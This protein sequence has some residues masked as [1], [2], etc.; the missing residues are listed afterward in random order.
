[1]SPGPFIPNHASPALRRAAIFMYIGGGLVA[2][3]GMLLVMGLVARSPEADQQMDRDIQRFMEQQKELPPGVDAPRLKRMAIAVG[4]S[5]GVAAFLAGVVQ[6]TLA[7][8]LRPGRRG[9]ALAGIIVGGCILVALGFLLL[10]ALVQAAGNPGA[11]VIVIMLAGPTVLC[12]LQIRWLMLAL[13]L[14]PS[15]GRMPPIPFAA[16][17]SPPPVPGLHP[18]LMVPAGQ[19]P[20]A[21]IDLTGPLPLP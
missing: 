12:I 14:M 20:V 2:L 8:A 1:M 10:A 13:R 19:P 7:L 18:A 6:I 11:L 15:G 9:A 21:D 5:M 16:A 3:G 17:G 4:I